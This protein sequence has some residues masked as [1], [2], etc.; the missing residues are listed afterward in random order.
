MGIGTG[1]ADFEREYPDRYFDVGIAEPHALTFSAGL[2][3]NGLKPFTAIYSTF[4]QRGYDNVVHDIALQS[5]PVKMFIDRAGLATADGATHHGIFDVAFL[6][7]IPEVEILAPSD[8]NSLR[9]SVLYA[10]STDTPVAVRYPNASESNI[11]SG[12]FSYA[13]KSVGV[14]LDFDPSKAPKNI[15]LT[16]GQIAENVI[17]AKRL[18]SDV[19]INV[20]IVLIERIKPYMPVASFLSRIITD[21][22][23]IVYVE[24]GI[25]AGGAAMITKDLL[26]GNAS[27]SNVRFDISAINDNFA[28]PSEPC[29][30]YDYVGL[31]PEKLVKYFLQ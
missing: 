11:I 14:K 25:Q 21:G 8:Y 17:E 9:E 19:G 7:H 24:E 31:S 29:N 10:Y 27:Y 5:L 2:A 28:S 3:A 13:D 22:C 30:L 18:L 16:Y 6:S 20:G 4:L 12:H 23:H 1:L 26:F 15:F